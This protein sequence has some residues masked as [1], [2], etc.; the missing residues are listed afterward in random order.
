VGAKSGQSKKAAG[1]KRLGLVVFGVLFAGLFVGFAIAEGIGQPS[2][3]AGDVALVEG[4]PSEIG[5]ISEA[6]FKR[7][8]EQQVARQ[9][10]KKTPKVGSKKYEELK[11]A[12][13]GE[14]IEGVW[15]VGEAE[16]L[17]V[18]V[19]QKQVETELKNIK[20]QSFPTEKKYQEFLK[21]SQLTQEEVDEKVELQVIATKVQEKVSAE[22]KPASDS[23]IQ[24]YYDAEKAKQFTEPP[25]RDVRVIVNEKKSEV[26]KAKEE[27]EKDNSA[28][29]WKKVAKKYSSDPS[30]NSKGGLQKAIPEEL[31]QGKL[32][33]AIYGTSVGELVGPTKFQGNYLLTEVVKL[34]PEKV[35]SLG[36]VRSQISQTLSQ[37]IQQEN[38]T[39]FVAEFR[40]RW[41]SQTFCASGFEVEQCANYPAAKR[42]EK[43]REAYKACYEANPKEPATECPAPVTQTKP[44]LPGSVSI[45]KPS[46][47][48]F[49]QRP[50]PEAG[51]SA[52]G[53]E[54]L[55][56]LEGAEGAEAAP[57]ATPEAEGGGETGGAESGE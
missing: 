1:V 30:T 38:F 4:V 6:D 16:D 21:E 13:M 54:A 44:A 17:D 5:H 45:A 32:K 25:T 29:N 18:K 28:A 27:L 24:E 42:L 8:L 7:A 33:K 52:A 50:R 34:N 2:V 14:L 22:A 9:K 47:E 11:A 46:G 48:Q 20:E 37:Q 40:S 56:G 12:V 41:S 55:E 31:L 51:A 39:E 10:L 23:E 19:T 36:E 43:E 57:E 53:S 3:P 15:I 26:E 49:V 35:K